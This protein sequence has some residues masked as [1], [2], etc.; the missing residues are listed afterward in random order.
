MSRALRTIA[1]GLIL[2]SMFSSLPA[3][4][5]NPECTIIAVEVTDAS[6]TE[7]LDKGVSKDSPVKLRLGNTQDSVETKTTISL[8][9]LE[10]NLDF[11]IAANKNSDCIGYLSIPGTNIQTPLVKHSS[12]NTYYLN[13]D[14]EKRYAGGTSPNA[15]EFI[16]SKANLSTPSQNS[17]NIIIYGHNWTNLEKFGAPPRVADSRD[18][19]FAQLASF[20]DYSFASRT[21]VFDLSSKTNDY[22]VVVFAVVYTDIYSAGNKTGFYYVEPN[23]SAEEFDYIVSTAK[24][25]SMYD[26]HV[27]VKPTDTLVTLSTCTRKLGGRSDQ[28]LVVM[29]RLLRNGE[30][31]S[32]AYGTL[33][34][35]K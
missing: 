20:G 16:D 15:A 14:L 22:K 11:Q 31:L 1:S 35:N 23:P 3:Y 34:L 17:K 29:G 2:A 28:R 12:D 9:P 19:Q 33:T 21:R 30:D 10:R 32:T 25:R 13:H 26:F 24:R 7:T 18:V 5:A 27:D 4:A 8:S 6:D